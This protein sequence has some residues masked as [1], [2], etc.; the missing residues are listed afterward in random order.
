M[1]PESISLESVECEADATFELFDST[2]EVA[3]QIDQVLMKAQEAG[4]LTV[5]EF[6]Q[7][8]DFY[9]NL[10]EIVTRLAYHL[11]PV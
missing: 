7:W 2:F 9:Q 1:D 11:R 10:Q 5:G 8:S 3:Q 6:N 4:H